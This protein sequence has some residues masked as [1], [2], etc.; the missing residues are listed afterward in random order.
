MHIN[1]IYLNT[2]PASHIHLHHHSVFKKEKKNYELV[3][4]VK[5]EHTNIIDQG[6]S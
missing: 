5:D 3:N 1:I 6:L 2:L 4:E